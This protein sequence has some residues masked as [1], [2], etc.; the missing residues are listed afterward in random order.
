MPNTEKTIV[1]QRVQEGKKSE[2]TPSNTMLRP[3]EKAPRLRTKALMA[4]LLVST[5]EHV[6]HRWTAKQPSRVPGGGP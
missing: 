4:P 2:T 1:N 3:H 6:S 5:P